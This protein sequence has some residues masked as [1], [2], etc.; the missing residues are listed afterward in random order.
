MKTLLA[1]TAAA[2][3]SCQSTLPP[4]TTLTATSGKQAVAVD[5]SGRTWK[6]AASVLLTQALQIG[7]QIAINAAV[8]KY[9]PPAGRGK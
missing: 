7:T 9:G 1:I 8:Q 4:G 2:L 3:C 6:E 5:A